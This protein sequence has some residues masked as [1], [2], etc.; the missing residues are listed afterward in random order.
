MPWSEIL[1]AIG[2]VLG[3]LAALWGIARWL[4][5]GMADLRAEIAALI[6]RIDV[7]VE[8]RRARDLHVDGALSGLSERATDHE[9]RLRDL[10]VA[11]VEARAVCP[12]LRGGQSCEV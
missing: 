5:Q 1:A 8:G 12:R 7:V 6:A 4:V 9:D 11:A 2:G 10:E 3:V